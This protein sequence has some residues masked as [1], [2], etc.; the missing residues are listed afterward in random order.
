MQHVGVYETKSYTAYIY[1]TKIIVFTPLQAFRIVPC[2]HYYKAQ[3]DQL[4]LEII[5]GK[6]IGI[7]DMQL[8]ED[9]LLWQNCK[10]P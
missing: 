5:D 4:K 1:A 7:S 8:K 9:K 6:I 2:R 10:R 3:L